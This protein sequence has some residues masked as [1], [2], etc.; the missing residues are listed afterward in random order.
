MSYCVNCGVEL[1]PGA[2][3]CPLCGQYAESME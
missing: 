2:Q 1:D 3:A